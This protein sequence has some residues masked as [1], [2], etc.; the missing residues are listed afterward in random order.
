M[1]LISIKRYL[2]GPPSEIYQ[3][4]LTLLI[5]TVAPHPVDVDH[6]ECERYRAGITHIQEHFPADATGEQL[7]EAAEA[8]SHL[9]ESYNRSVT[10]FVHRQG[11]ELQNMISMLTGT[12][13]SLGSASE[14]SAKN[15]E[16][17]ETQLKRASALEDIHQLRLRLAECLHKVRDEA[18]RQKNEN[19]VNLDSLKNELASSQHRMAHHG[20]ASVTDPVTGLASRSAAEV[21]IHEAAN[22]GDIRYLLVA[23]LGKMQSINARFGYA[24]GDEVLCEFAARVAGRLCSNASFFRWNGPTI[25]GIL[26]RPQPMHVVR[27]EAGRVLEAPISKSLMNGLQNAFITT[28][29]AWSLFPITPPGAELIT[30]ID[31]FVVGQIPKEFC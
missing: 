16:V 31:R 9:I 12:I 22:I 27:A 24:V 19:Q 28:S 23:V 6:A 10:E 8:I 26:K 29:A 14:H 1:A 7:L 2:D 3:R 18:A 11:D 20:I 17:I 5:D 21:A 4:L 30:K 25:V 13:K 15:L